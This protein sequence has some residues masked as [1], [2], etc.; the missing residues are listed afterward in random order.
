MTAVK[1]S[2]PRRKFDAVIIVGV[3]KDRVP[4]Q[5]I[6]FEGESYHYL[7]YAWHN[8]MYVAVT[9]AKFVVMMLGEKSRGPS[10]ILSTA[11]NNGVLQLRSK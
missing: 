9:R 7:N 3:D 5:S 8:R 10:K 1:T 4:P 11:I 2:L 6:D